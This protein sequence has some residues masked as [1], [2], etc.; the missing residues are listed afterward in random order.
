M[1]RLILPVFFLLLFRAADAVSGEKLPD[2]ALDLQF[3]DAVTGVGVHLSVLPP[4][5]TLLA[6]WQS[7]CEPCL[8]DFPVLSDFAATQKN[9]R[10][11]GVS[12]S[13]R[14]TS[15]RD[16]ENLRMPFPT[17]VS[18]EFPEVLLARF[19]DPVA[20]VP[21]SVML[22]AQRHACWSAVGQINAVQLQQALQDC[23]FTP[24][25]K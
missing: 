5:I 16:W 9:V 14:R 1:P 23:G 6:F 17:L 8:K 3:P 19:G 20:A 13:D 15:R 22:D 11:L 2:Q 12:I 24:D 25:Q 18:N 7:G 21:Y 10:V 4:Q